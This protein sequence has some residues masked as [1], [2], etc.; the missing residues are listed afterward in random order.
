MLALMM[1]LIAGFLYQP[2]F[3]KTRKLIFKSFYP[4]DINRSPDYELSM[5]SQ[6]LLMVVGLPFLFGFDGLLISL[7]INVL[8]ELKL[9]RASFENMSRNIITKEN[10]REALIQLY[11]LIDHHNLILKY[12]R[13]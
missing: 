10:T 2:V 12:Y 1:V 4:Q 6:V 3:G 7:I 13:W 8:C 5:F 11:E 9:L